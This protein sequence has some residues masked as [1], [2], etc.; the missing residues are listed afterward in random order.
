[1]RYTNNYSNSLFLVLAFTA[2]HVWAQNLTVESAIEEAKQKKINPL[3]V[4]KHDAVN[5][6]VATAPIALPKNPSENPNEEPKLWSIKGIKENLTAEFVYKNSIH[7]INL[8]EKAKFADWTI[9]EYDSESVTLVKQQALPSPSRQN[10]KESSQPPSPLKLF[11][12]PTGSSIVKF[13]IPA[14]GEINTIQRQAASNLPIKSS[15]R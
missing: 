12:P 2:S 1:M 6:P 8:H 7:S 10:K 11:I 13:N 5:A 9:V 14:D 4:A 15:D 3:P